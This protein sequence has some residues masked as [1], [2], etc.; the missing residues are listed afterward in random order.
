MTIINYIN[1]NPKLAEIKGIDLNNSEAIVTMVMEYN[2]ELM[3][4]SEWYGS[5]V[6]ESSSLYIIPND[7]VLEQI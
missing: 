5:R 6:Y 7:M 3:G 2:E 4:S 1:D